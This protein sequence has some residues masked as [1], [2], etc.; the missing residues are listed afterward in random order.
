V[1][2]ELGLPFLRVGGRL[3]T[4]KGSR[5]S[6]EVEGASHA[7]EVLHGRAF[8]VPFDVPGPPQVLVAVVKGAS[9][10]AEY[11]RRAGMPAKRPL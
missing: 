6:E 4:T 8:V 2:V 11:P 3:V 1:L 9:T 7:L 5:A 10:P